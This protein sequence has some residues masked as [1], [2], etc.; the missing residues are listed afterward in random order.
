MDTVLLFTRYPTPGRCKSRLVPA[1]GPRGAAEVQ[2]QLTE[3][4]VA[5][6]KPGAAAGRYRLVIAY[7]G[8]SQR[9]MRTWLGPAPVWLK[10]GTGG[11]GERLNRAFQWAFGH[12]A[13][14]VVAIG[15]DCPEVTP[16]L[17]SDAFAALERSPLVL[18]PA[19]DGGYYL[20]GLRRPCPELFRNIPWGT[21]DVLQTTLDR[22]RQLGLELVL[23]PTL[24]DVDEPADLP[25]WRDLRARPASLSV[26]IPTLNEADQIATTLKAVTAEQPDE[27]LVA[28]G[29]STDGTVERAEH[30]GARVL[31]VPKG[32]AR[33]MNAAAAMA[34]SDLLFFLHADTLPPAGYV[35]SIRH[36][37]ENPAVAAGAFR[38][39]LREPLARAALVEALVAVRCALFGTPFGDQGLF[40]RR[41]LFLALG[42]FADLPLLEDVEILTRLRRWGAVK[43][44]R[45]P[46]A[47]SARRWQRLGLLRTFLLNHLI[48]LGYYA[49]VSPDR[50]A[51]LY[52]RPEPPGPL[53]APS[54]CPAQPPANRAGPTRIVS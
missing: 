51:R 54:T 35:Q 49:G 13:S 45:E 16:P 37:L 9:A 23:L 22:A 3:W 6:L 28:D 26:V 42:G 33:Q 47:T 8:A 44:C 30:A 10:Q 46:A 14:R 53:P 38:F 41:D 5:R 19:R 50:L 17:L 31:R 15:A 2:R 7:T 43:L 29:G 20:V 24:R 1:L 4:L 52:G 27:I 32:R 25:Y 39:A 21:S 12:G 48:M 34:R 40:V 36:W 18:G 11:L